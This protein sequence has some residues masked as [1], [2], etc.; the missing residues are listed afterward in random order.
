MSGSVS[1]R[2]AAATKPARPA[3]RRPYPPGVERRLGHDFARVR[4]H[5]DAEGAA[6]PR[7]R[8]ADAF[9]VGE[10]LAF[11]AGSFAPGTCAGDELL[12]HELAHV[13]QQ[14]PTRDAP[15]ADPAARRARGRRRRA[16][17]PTP[18]LPAPDRR[19]SPAR[20]GEAE[21]RAGETR[22]R[23]HQGRARRSAQG[24]GRPRREDHRRRQ[25][26]A[27]A[28]GAQGREVSGPGPR[29]RD[30]QAL[31]SQ[32]LE[33]MGSRRERHGLRPDRHGL[34]RRATRRGR[35]ARTSRRSSSTTRSISGTAPS[36]LPPDTRR[37]G[38]TRRR[39]P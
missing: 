25:G 27:D 3:P 12:A 1:P 2:G 22:R 33:E 19:P 32:D 21:A 24:T 13:V 20:Q 26:P 4:I 9:T 16:R 35:P 31:A 5:A 7:A 8:H 10:E 34:L 17:P 23:N 38:S 15:S 37:P 11:A 6:R 29:G 39:A 30:R 28:G 14:R 36:S 18:P